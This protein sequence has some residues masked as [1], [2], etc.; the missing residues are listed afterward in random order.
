MIA[1]PQVIQTTAQAAATIHLTIPRSEMMKVFG[2]AVGE[3]MS[4]LAT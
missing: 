1:T 3:L 4:A 2:P